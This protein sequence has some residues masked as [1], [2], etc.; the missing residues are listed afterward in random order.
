[1]WILLCYLCSRGNH[2]WK[3][4]QVGTSHPFRPPQLNPP[5]RAPQGQACSTRCSPAWLPSLDQQI[6]LRWQRVNQLVALPTPLQ[7]LILHRITMEPYASSPDLQKR[8]CLVSRS[9]LP[10]VCC[11]V[12]WELIDDKHNIPEFTAPRCC[13]PPSYKPLQSVTTMTEQDRRRENSSPQLSDFFNSMK[14]WE[15]L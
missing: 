8:K 9:S 10:S 7:N 12:V 13:L 3:M 6:P 15:V 2:P 5:E 1:M 11:D 14:L 4:T